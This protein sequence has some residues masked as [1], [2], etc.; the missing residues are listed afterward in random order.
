M[1]WIVDPVIADISLD[2]GTAG[3]S[4]PISA[5][6]NRRLFEAVEGKTVKRLNI[7]SAGGEV[8]AGIALG[9]WVS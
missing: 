7:T 3:Y 6:L 2:A 5:E 4:G 1:P 8:E 9:V